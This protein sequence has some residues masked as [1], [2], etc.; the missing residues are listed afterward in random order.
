[1]SKAH[2]ITQLLNHLSSLSDF[3]NKLLSLLIAILIDL[4]LQLQKQ[5][6]DVI[7]LTI[8]AIYLPISFTHWLQQVLVLAAKFTESES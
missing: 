8:Q 1:M 4:G 7:M 3:I 6:K 2:Q 5:K